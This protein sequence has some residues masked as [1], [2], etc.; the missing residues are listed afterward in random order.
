ML[1][2]SDTKYSVKVRGALDV[3]SLLRSDSTV[4]K[5]KWVIASGI[6]DLLIPK[7]LSPKTVRPRGVCPFWAPVETWVAT[8]RPPWRGPLP[9]ET[10]RAHAEK[11]ETIIHLDNIF[12]CGLIRSADTKLYNV[13]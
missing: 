4:R 2:F 6:T 7:M 3:L 1:R 12:N 9:M 13:P 5:K 8:W 11:K 10:E